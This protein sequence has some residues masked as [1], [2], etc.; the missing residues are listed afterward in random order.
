MSHR[1]GTQC[2]DWHPKHSYQHEYRLILFLSSSW[3]G[4]VSTSEICVCTRMM[5]LSP[6]AGLGYL[7]FCREA[8]Q[9]LL[10]FTWIY[11]MNIW[12][13]ESCSPTLVAGT[14]VSSCFKHTYTIR[15]L[16]YLLPTTS[17]PNS[18]LSDCWSLQKL[19]GS[20]VPPIVNSQTCHLSSIQFHLHTQW[21]ECY[22]TIA[23]NRIGGQILVSMCRAQSGRHL[24]SSLHST[25]PS[26]WLSS[27][28][29]HIYSPSPLWSFPFPVFG[30][31]H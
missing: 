24:A 22:L 31:S 14:L 27:P 15:S 17:I 2:P 3:L 7:V 21:L 16:Q 11:S 19:A 13:P 29:S 18:Q 9:D 26:Y 6:R 28:F 10:V 4:L 1:E 23:F 8:G 5:W 12:S 20:K 30:P 25:I